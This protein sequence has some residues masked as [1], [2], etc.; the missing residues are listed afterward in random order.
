VQ[1]ELRHPEAVEV[2]LVADDHVAEARIGGNDR[3]GVPG[4]LLPL[5]DAQRRRPRAGVVDGE[6]DADALQLRRRVHV[7]EHHRL[8]RGRLAQARLPE[9][10]DPHRLEAG[11]PEQLHL[12]LR[13][14]RERATDTVFGGSENDG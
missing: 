6:I 2:R 5:G 7:R 10:R 12:E 11:E 13:L 9:A 8:V 1:R 3:G 4:E 14:G